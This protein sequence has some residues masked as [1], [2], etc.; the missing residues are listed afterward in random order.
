MHSC[1]S[2]GRASLDRALPGYRGPGQQGPQLGPPEK[3]SPPL[4]PVLCP[5]AGGM[6]AGCSGSQPPSLLPSESLP[7][8]PQAHLAWPDAPPG[9][10]VPLSSPW[11]GLP[12]GSG[13]LGVLPGDLH[14]V[15][16]SS[17][18]A[19][20]STPLASLRTLHDSPGLPGPAHQPGDGLG[21][22]SDVPGVAP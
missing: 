3:S 1:T 9:S 10:R 5:L 2:A 19:S 12:C 4:S 22:R 21:Q 11:S 16:R 14:P 17:H 20:P 18:T 15:V 8:C 13:G 6:V 7:G